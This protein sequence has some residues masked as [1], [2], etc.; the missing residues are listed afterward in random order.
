MLL[1]ADEVEVQ[2]LYAVLF[3][4]VLS[5][6]AAQVDARLRQRVVF[7][8]RGVPL[9]RAEATSV[10]AHVQRLFGSAAQRVA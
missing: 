4:Q 3:K 9:Y 6:Q 1:E 5:N 7:I 10:V 8:Q 2:V